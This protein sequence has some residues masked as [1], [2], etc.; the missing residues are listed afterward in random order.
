[1]AELTSDGIG[2]DL[3]GYVDAF[4][5]AWRRQGGAEPAHYL[6]PPS[7]PIYLLV[8]RELVRVDLEFNWSKGRPKRL[9]EYQRAFP[10]L[11][12][13]PEAAREIALEECRLRRQA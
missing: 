2:R 9:E 4:E 13:D 8:L 5:S 3:H 1:M 10:A 11:F 6:P 7:D 12:E